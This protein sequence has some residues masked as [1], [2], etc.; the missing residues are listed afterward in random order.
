VTG[1]AGIVVVVDEVVS[2][3]VIDECAA[4]GF[5]PRPSPAALG[6]RGRTRVA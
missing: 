4:D 3:C 5:E 1:S 2:R 6:R